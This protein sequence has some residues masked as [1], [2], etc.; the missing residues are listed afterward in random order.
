MV[1]INLDRPWTYRTPEKTIAYPAGEHSVF[2]Y[3]ADK[4]AED[5]AIASAEIGTADPLDGSVPQL[6]EYLAGVED[7]KEL[8][9]MRAAEVAGKTRTTAI[10]AIDVR[11]AEIEG[12]S[13]D[14]E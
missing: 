11:I 1:T 10:N 12:S 2:Q 13:G 6:T 5:G 7:V 4:A 8:R 14:T 9:R 3:V